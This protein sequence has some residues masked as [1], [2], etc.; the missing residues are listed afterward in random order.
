MKTLLKDMPEHMERIEDN[1]SLKGHIQDEIE[2]NISVCFNKTI[3]EYSGGDNARLYIDIDNLPILSE[4]LLSV[5][6][7]FVNQN[8]EWK[9]V[10]S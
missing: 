9:G 6:T 8:Y 10:K 2:Q 3:G 4:M 7:D 5:I 1:W